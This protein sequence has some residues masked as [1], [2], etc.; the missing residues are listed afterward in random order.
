LNAVAITTAAAAL[1]D[2]P[3]SCPTVAASFPSV[4]VLLR[5]FEKKKKQH[6]SI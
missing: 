6:V 5:L 1:A 3:S 4:F 2:S